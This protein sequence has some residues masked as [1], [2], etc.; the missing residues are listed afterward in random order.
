MFSGGI[1]NL[2]GSASYVLDA[3]NVPAATGFNSAPVS[4]F[5]ML[6][7]SEGYS[8][9]ANGSTYP[10]QVGNLALGAEVQNQSWIE[11]SK[12]INGSLITNY[13]FAEGQIPSNSYGLH[14]GSAQLGIPGSLYLGGYDQLRIVGPVSV[15]SYDQSSL[16]IDLLDISIGVAE[17]GSPFPYTSKTGLLAQ[18]NI[19][20]G[21]SLAVE[22]DPKEPYLYLPSSTCQAIARELPVTFQPDFGFYL[23][24]TADPLYEKI[25]TSPAYL[26]F[27]FR[28]NNS[29]TQNFTINI[30]FALLNLTLSDPLATTP[31][32]YFPCSLPRLPQFRLGRSFL[33]AAFIGINWETNYEGVWFLAQAP[34]PNIALAPNVLSIE[35]TD[36]FVLQ[37]KND[38]ADSWSKTWVALPGNNSTSSTPASTS[39][40]SGPVISQTSLSS[41]AKAGIAIAAVAVCALA[42]G[43]AELWWRQKKRPIQQQA[44]TGDGPFN[45]VADEVDGKWRRAEMDS[46]LQH[47]K[48]ELPAKGPPSY[49]LPVHKSLPSYE[50]A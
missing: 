2:T 4:S 39:N 22:I 47:A 38:W 1:Q 34:G 48:I 41:S 18:G 28:L 45:G 8:I 19:T 20:I 24:N 6:V 43:A 40:G 32:P 25:I 11:G 17:G 37:S 15:Q 21:G 27:T 33:Q 3:M 44:L 16:P 46:G 49:E 30:P 23:W 35:P 7:V 42:V 9:L 14:I 31:T 5:D 50:L 26:G 36:Q 29:I 13:L 10:V 12:Q